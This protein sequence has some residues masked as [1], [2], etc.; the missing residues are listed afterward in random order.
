MSLSRR[1]ALTNLLLVLLFGVA[2][3][4]F[5][6]AVD[7]GGGDAISIAPPTERSF[8]KES[9][10]FIT[11]S[12]STADVITI[13]AGHLNGKLY[14]PDALRPSRDQLR[15]GI[16]FDEDNP[17]CC[18]IAS[19]PNK[20]K[21]ITCHGTCFLP[22]AC[23]DKLYPFQ[24]PSEQSFYQLRNVT[25]KN[26]RVVGKVAVGSETLMLQQKCREMNARFQPP[27]QW[28][29]QWLRSDGNASDNN[30]IIDPYEANLPPAG[31]SLIPGTHSAYQNLLLFPSSSSQHN[32]K[33]S[34]NH[35]ADDGTTNNNKLAFCGIPKNGITNW[36]QLLRFVVGAPDYLSVP[37]EKHDYKKFL[38]DALDEHVQLD[39][40]NDD[41]Y[42]FAAFLRDPAERLLS[43]YL[44]KI[45]GSDERWKKHFVSR[46]GLNGTP[47]F[48][49]FVKMLDGERTSCPLNGKISDTRR[50]G[51]IDW[52]TDE[53][54]APQTFNCGLSEFLPRFKF[55]GSLN[56][57]EHQAKQ[58]LQHV[59]LWE[60]YGRYYH[61]EKSFVPHSS[62]IVPPPELKVGDMLSGFQQQQ[63]RMTKKDKMVPTKEQGTMKFAHHSTQSQSKVDEY[64]TEELKAIVKRLYA[65]DYKVW[66]LIKDEEELMSGRELA[67]KLSS[68]CNENAIS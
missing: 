42:V 65:N 39:I 16:I 18:L 3:L 47:T 38:F 28:C 15:T 1:K 4:N 13:E 14:L 46:Y 9:L 41:S 12:K 60:S 5:F 36:I 54:W 62:C 24:S 53:H 45:N 68:T 44:D 51:G 10:P 33:I 67:M 25:F 20:P 23:A 55:I 11:N 56:R 50:L 58:I 61:E 34:S 19:A 8:S 17:L 40:L 27:Y 2:C 37:Y 7:S 31:C 63:R 6:I 52:C 43:L 49:A 57:V 21:R 59:G 29:H 30:H 22:R 66:N 64:Y 35:H 48:E 32:R 26:R